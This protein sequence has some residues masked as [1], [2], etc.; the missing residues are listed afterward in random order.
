MRPSGCAN[1][2]NET[3]MEYILEQLFKKRCQD[4]RDGPGPLEGR[5]AATPSCGDL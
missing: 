4:A 1:I 5:R 2:D 3:T